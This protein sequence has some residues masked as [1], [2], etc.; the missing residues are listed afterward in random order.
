MDTV[1]KKRMGF[2]CLIAAG[3]FLFNPVVAFVDILPNCIGYLLI[4]I[5]LGRMMDMEGHIAEAQKKFRTLFLFSLVQML[6]S[7]I[8]FNVIQ[9]SMYTSDGQEMK[10]NSY[11]KPVYILL[12]S[13]VMLVIQW[14]FLIP[15]WKELFAGMDRLADRY[16]AG[17]WSHEKKGRTAARRMSCF[18]AVTVTVASLLSL[19][20]ELSVL[21]S[22]E[23]EAQNAHFPFDWYEYIVLFRWVCGTASALLS[24]VWLFF[25]VRFFLC[26]KRDKVW[27]KNLESAYAAVL[28]EQSGMLTVR[29]FSNAFLLLQIGIV[30]SV[31]IRINECM[32][33][34]GVVFAVFTVLSLVWLGK[35]APIK[36]GCYVS[37]AALACVSIA[38]ISVNENYLKLYRPEEA[39]YR[40]DAYWCFLPV[41]ILEIAEAFLT[42]ALV[43]F[44][45]ASLY[46][47]VRTHTHAA[48]SATDTEPS[49]ADSSFR[50]F[51]TRKNIILLIFLFAAV[52]NA[53][54]AYFQLE[55]PWLW[56]VALAI[57]ITGICVFYSFLYELKTQIQFRYH[58]NGVNKNL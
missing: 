11:E 25:F 40:P 43:G 31:G 29:R 50:Y 12:G 19:L 41:R 38:Q 8:I 15:A 54:E 49:S 22:F 4:C 37:G 44:L 33:L 55:Y 51:K 23:K 2:G 26:G 14:Y 21:T 10:I 56:L 6:A 39:L 47:I 58:S 53:L 24:L 32:A 46:A 57:S 18:S 5:G 1:Q 27:Q 17:V 16:D 45:M 20:P 13:F 52:A 30:F 34:P 35:T 48:Y 36:K 42:F 9:R 7:Y 28:Q 3:F